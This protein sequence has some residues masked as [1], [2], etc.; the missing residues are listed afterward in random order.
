MHNQ[1]PIQLKREPFAHIIVDEFLDIKDFTELVSIELKPVDDGGFAVHHNTIDK[2]MFIE[3][4]CLNKDLI[5]KI[6]NSWHST[7]LDMLDM[8]SPGKSRYYDYSEFHMVQTGKN[9]S[10]PIHHDIRSKL[11]S[12][13]VYLDPDCSTGTYIYRNECPSTMHSE[14]QWKVNRALIFARAER[15]TWHSYRG[16]GKGERRCLVY[17]LMTKRPEQA[18]KAEGLS[19]YSLVLSDALLRAKKRL[20]DLRVQL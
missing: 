2:R 13:V 17:N 10:F 6:H 7:L 18:M 16:D 12:I 4:S 5:L 20:R 9:F 8:L 11:L 19:Y 14:I 15:Q 3:N 1:K